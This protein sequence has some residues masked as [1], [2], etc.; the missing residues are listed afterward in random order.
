MN[1]FFLPVCAIALTGIIAYNLFYR[2]DIASQEKISA[3][4]AR[5]INLEDV[6]PA[7]KLSKSHQQHV[8]NIQQC[9]ERSKFMCAHCMKQFYCSEDHQKQD[10]LAD[11]AAMCSNRLESLAS[12][13]DFSVN[14]MHV[15]LHSKRG[16]DVDP[17]TCWGTNASA[18]FHCNDC[19]HTWMSAKAFIEINLE[20]LIV[21]RTYSQSCKNCSQPAQPEF[22]NLE[23]DIKQLF[24]WLKGLRDTEKWFRSDMSDPHRA[25]L[26]EKCGFGAHPHRH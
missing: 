9:R 20:R 17:Y 26:C 7:F 8:C 11:H 16:S 24:E 25:D 14:R 23:S 1:P 5:K 4:S 21:T 6:P 15:Q 12:D 10:Y 13:V 18:R 22:E 3:P 19:G 2:E